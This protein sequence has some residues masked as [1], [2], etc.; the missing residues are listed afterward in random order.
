MNWKQSLILSRLPF[1]TPA[2]SILKPCLFRLSYLINTEI[3]RFLIP[4]H[5][6]K[7][8]SDRRKSSFFFSRILAQHINTPTR[9]SSHSPELIRV[10]SRGLSHT[11]PKYLKWQQQDSQ[12][13]SPGT[14][15]SASQP[16]SSALCSCCGLT[17]N[18]TSPCKRTWES[19][20]HEFTQQH[21]NFGSATI[22]MI[23][24]NLKKNS[25]N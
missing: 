5:P 2:L 12:D 4:P 22:L 25:K 15:A 7:A 9:D 19:H 16:Q 21:S 23:N 17:L 3:F 20:T 6:G 18:S 11:L 13:L 24:H 10:T 8:G 1:I 14:R